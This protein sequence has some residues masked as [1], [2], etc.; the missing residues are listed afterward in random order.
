MHLEMLKNKQISA[1][2]LGMQSASC[3]SSPAPEMIM[4]YIFLNIN[5]SFVFIPSSYDDV[6]K[7]VVGYFVR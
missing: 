1:L 7:R 5:D 3:L 2:L 4:A 6:L